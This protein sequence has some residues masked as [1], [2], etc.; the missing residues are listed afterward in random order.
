MGVALVH[1]GRWPK[2]DPSGR[3]VN[4]LNP[5]QKTDLG[6]SSAVHSTEVELLPATPADLPNAVSEDRH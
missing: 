6:E 4:A 2:F 5:G 3:N 1:K